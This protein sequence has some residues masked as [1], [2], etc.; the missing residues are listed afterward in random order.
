[1]Q[2][3]AFVNFNKKYSYP[4]YFYSFNSAEDESNNNNS[5]EKEHRLYFLSGF[6]AKLIHTTLQKS[7]FIQ[8]DNVYLASI[9]VGSKPNEETQKYLKP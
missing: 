6:S 5:N 8:T 9:I 7:G 3:V 4:V 1:M 2:S